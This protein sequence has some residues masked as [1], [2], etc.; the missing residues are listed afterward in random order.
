MDTIT[1]GGLGGAALSQGIKFL[2]AQAGEVLKRRR[3]RREALE[4]G[5]QQSPTTLEVATSDVLDG[6]LASVTLDYSVVDQFAA[7]LSTFRK[8]LSEH[9][10]GLVDP[11]PADRQLLEQ[12]DGL[13]CGLEEVFGQRITFRGEQREPTGAPVVRGVVRGGEVYG[14]VTGVD[15]EQV[16]TG[17]VEGTAEVDV[18]HEGGDVSGVR[19][20]RLGG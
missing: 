10:E 16:T 19:V 7:E 14:R 6:P 13:R 4:A 11:D 8:A 18:V 1:L 9:A 5:E 15:T 3:D 2:Y 20:R 17:S 12:I